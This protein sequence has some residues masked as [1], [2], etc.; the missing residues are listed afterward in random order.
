MKL[1]SEQPAFRPVAT[2]RFY[3]V[4]AALVGPLEKIL[5]I[6]CRDFTQLAS[7]KLDRSLT[8]FERSR[9]FLH[10]LMCGLCRRQER[11]MRQLNRLAGDVISRAGRDAEVKLDAEARER[12]RERLERELKRH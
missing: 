10:R 2:P 6:T 11:R 9:Y 8:V 5:G 7:I 1:P 3:R 12:I 4:L